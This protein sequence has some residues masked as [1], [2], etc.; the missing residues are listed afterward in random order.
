MYSRPVKSCSPSR[1]A[2]GAPCSAVP[3]HP[4]QGALAGYLSKK[5]RNLNL[6]IRD[7]DCSQGGGTL[8]I[9]ILWCSRW[10][11]HLCMVWS[12]HGKP[13]FG[14]FSCGTNSNAEGQHANF[15]VF[16][17]TGKITAVSL[18]KKFIR[19]NPLSSQKTAQM[20]FLVDCALL[21]FFLHGDVVWRH[22]ID[23]RVDSGWECWIQVSSPVIFCY[24]K[25]S[26][27]VSYRCKRPAVTTFLAF[28]A[29]CYHYACNEHRPCNSQS[30]S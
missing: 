6:M 30:R 13:H 4:H 11:A 20:L 21:N 16:Q 25:P 9:R 18:G 27:P 15:L 29:H 14:H 24:T 1:A 22:S 19:T 28:T 12:C 10:C 8:S 17:Y 26:F 23:C 5:Q 3:R 7:Q 2:T